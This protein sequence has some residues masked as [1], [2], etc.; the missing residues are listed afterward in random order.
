[1]WVEFLENLPR[2]QKSICNL[3]DKKAA[4]LTSRRQ[5]RFKTTAAPIA[6]M[7]SAAIA[8]QPM[9]IA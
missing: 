1:V 4:S 7:T 8:G 6:I 9:A 5:R 3:K 2:L